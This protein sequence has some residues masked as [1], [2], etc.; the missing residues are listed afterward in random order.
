MESPSLLTARPVLNAFLVILLGSSC[1]FFT[2]LYKARMLFMEKKRMGLVCIHYPDPYFDKSVLI[3]YRTALCTSSQFPLRASP[4][5]QKANGCP[6][7]ECSLSV[8]VCRHCTRAFSIRRPLL[9]RSVAR[10]WSDDD[11]DI[12]K[13]CS[14]SNANQHKDLLRES[15]YGK[16]VLQTHCGRAEPFRHGRKGVETLE[17]HFCQRVQ[18]RARH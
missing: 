18:Y 14:S 3:T 1:Y 8:H 15:V 12:R 7:Q 4:L 11:C 9:R 16:A 2:Q 10:K 13:C 6:A 17:S 5:S